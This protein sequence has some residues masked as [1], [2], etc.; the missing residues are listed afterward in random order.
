MSHPRATVAVVGVPMTQ[1]DIRTIISE[2]RDQ[3]N[4]HVTE[5]FSGLKVQMEKAAD[6][7]RI[8]HDKLIELS[9]LMT[10]TSRDVSDL[11]VIYGQTAE[12]IRQLETELGS[13]RTLAEGIRDLKS[14]LEKLRQSESEDAAKIRADHAVELDKLRASNARECAALRKDV[15][16][17]KKIKWQIG[18][19]VATTCAIVGTLLKLFKI[20]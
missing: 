18:A 10:G 5:Q 15:D 11:R 9:T 4:G 2:I 1:E 7:Q 16:D 20:L 14:Q 6:S 12:R 17:L 13:S 8:D 3:L 19:A